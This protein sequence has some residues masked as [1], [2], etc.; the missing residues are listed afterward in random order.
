MEFGILGFCFDF[1]G[2]MDVTVE[3]VIGFVT[4]ISL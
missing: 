2:R 4:C 3:V 1:K